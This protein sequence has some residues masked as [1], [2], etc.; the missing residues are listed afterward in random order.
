MER[1]AEL[2]AQ[3]VELKDPEARAAFLRSH[4]GQQSPELAE[5]Q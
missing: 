1:I 5:I 3:V 2:F 4:L